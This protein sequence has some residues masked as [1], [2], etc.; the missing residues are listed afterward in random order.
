VI[1]KRQKACQNTKEDKN[2]DKKQVKVEDTKAFKEMQTAF[3]RNK[4]KRTWAESFSAC[5]HSSVCFL[6]V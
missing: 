5:E 3:D 1:Y 4:H 2:K 6:F